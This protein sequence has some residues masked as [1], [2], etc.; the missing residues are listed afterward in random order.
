MVA[1]ECVEREVLMSGG[2]VRGCVSEVRSGGW[3]YLYGRGRRKEAVQDDNNLGWQWSTE[4]ERRL[5]GGTS[6]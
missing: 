2:S 6:T 5:H 1:G 3:R 4:V